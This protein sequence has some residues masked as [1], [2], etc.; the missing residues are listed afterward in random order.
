MDDNRFIKEWAENIDNTLLE[1][2]KAETMVSSLADDYFLGTREYH[3]NNNYWELINGYKQAQTFVLIACDYLKKVE[4]R[5]EGTVNI[6]YKRANSKTET[7]PDT[8]T[9]TQERV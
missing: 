6:M 9:P 4:R 8:V 3:T 2:E 7:D 5:L 1:L